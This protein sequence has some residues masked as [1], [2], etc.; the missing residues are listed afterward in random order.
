M[1][2]WIPPT[3][4][5]LKFNIY[6]VARVKSRLARIG[7]LRNHKGNIMLMFSKNASTKK[8]N[9]AANASVEA[10][11]IFSASFQDKLIIESIVV[12]S[13]PFR[14]IPENM[15]GLAWDGMDLPKKHISGQSCRPVL[16]K[17]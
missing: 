12:N 15:P 8:S 4:G 13:L 6:G 9:K 5:V 11:R 16:A 7:V 14:P 10:P 2:H 1:V 17:N 3:V